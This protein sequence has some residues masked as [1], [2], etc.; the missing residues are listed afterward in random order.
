[1]STIYG[2]SKYAIEGE[3]AAKVYETV[4]DSYFYKTYSDCLTIDYKEGLLLIVEEW[5][6]YP[7]F[8]DFVLP[9]LIGDN[10]YWWVRM[11]ETG[12]IITNDKEGKYFTIEAI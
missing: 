4:L 11:E 5:S 1:M 7:G 9:F 2:T 12:K 3:N 8:G 6:N 10:Y